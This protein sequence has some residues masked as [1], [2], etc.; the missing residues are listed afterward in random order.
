MNPVSITMTQEEYQLLNEL[1]ADHFGLYFPEH[2]KEIFESRVKPRLYALNLSSYMDYYYLLQFNSNG[3]KELNHFG[4]IVTNNETYF[5]RETHQFDALFS[6]AANELQIGASPNN[7][8]RVLCAGC[9]SGEEAYT[10]N[11]I[12]KENQ[13]RIGNSIQVDAFDLSDNCIE[14]AIRGEY[15]P[16]SLRTIGEDLISRYFMSSASD[17]YRLKSLFRIG[18]K[19]VVGNILNL[20]SYPGPL[21]YDV[22]FCR[23]VFIYFSESALHK[24]INNFAH[25]LRQGGLLFLGHSE[26]IIGISKYFEAIRLGNCIAYKKVIS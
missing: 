19:F 18:V 25:S 13:F 23:N 8:L 14:M 17:G 1:L 11:I 9:S 12:S 2:K 3:N 5:F 22:I 7:T 15:S 10:L 16:R 21:P 26:S 24:A 4:R 6:Q 20:S